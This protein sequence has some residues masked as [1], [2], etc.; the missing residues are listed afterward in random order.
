MDDF[1]YAYVTTQFVCSNLLKG[2]QCQ[3]IV[4]SLLFLIDSYS[5][6]HIYLLT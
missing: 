3:T 4:C 1:E 2:F 6:L 5:S